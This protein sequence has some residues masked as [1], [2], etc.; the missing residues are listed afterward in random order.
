ML[1]D[2][3]VTDLT[4]LTPLNFDVFIYDFRGYGQS[5]GTSRFR[6]IINDYVEL[7]AS[8]NGQ[9]Y[10]KKVLLG[11]SFGGVILANVIGRGAKFDAVIFD[12][13]P[14]SNPGKCPSERDSIKNIP[15][16]AS[17]IGM[18]L[19]EQDKVVRPSEYEPLSDIIQQNGGVKR[20]L[21]TLAH[22]FQ[23][24]TEYRAIREQE[25]ISLIRRLL[26]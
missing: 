21:G 11:I 25:T 20:K 6:A 18:I 8:L 23:D 5:N 1:S 16:N 19:G 3:I 2:Q 4:F 12:S 13:V 17:N 22:P 10:S 15:Q 26:P 14:A 24:T 7:V 9:G